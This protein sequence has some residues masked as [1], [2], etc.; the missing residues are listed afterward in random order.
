METL[1]DMQE[2]LIRAYQEEI[3]TL[4]Q[5]LK[6]FE[7][8]MHSGLRHYPG[9]WVD[10]TERDREQAEDGIARYERA[11]AHIPKEYRNA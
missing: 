11:I 6:A 1:R 3:D 9:P 2:D 8:G 10:T 7:I 5:R 4:R